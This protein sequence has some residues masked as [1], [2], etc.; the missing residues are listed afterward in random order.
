MWLAL[1]PMPVARSWAV[2][3]ATLAVVEF[4]C[5]RATGDGVPRPTSFVALTTMPR[6]ERAWGAPV[7]G[8]RGTRMVYVPIMQLLGVL[9][10][11]TLISSQRSMRLKKDGLKSI[12]VVNRPSVTN[13]LSR[14]I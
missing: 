2:L 6:V 9:S 12:V 5:K 13:T 1:G 7:M 4:T 11:R 14:Q 3:S 8:W 10:A